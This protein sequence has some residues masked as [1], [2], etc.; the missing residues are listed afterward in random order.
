MKTKR[1]VL[2]EINSDGW[3]AAVKS[4]HT[5]KYDG[6]TSPFPKEGSSKLRQTPIPWPEKQAGN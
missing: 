2:L 1:T 3:Q 6:S 4:K 5:F